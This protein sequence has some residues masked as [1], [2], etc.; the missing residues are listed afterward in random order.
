MIVKRHWLEELRKLDYAD[1]PKDMFRSVSRSRRVWMT[2]LVVAL[3]IKPMRLCGMISQK[4]EM[5]FFL[6][7]Q[8]QKREQQMIIHLQPK[9]SALLA[10]IK[11]RRMQFSVKNVEIN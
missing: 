11:T 1:H 5:S 2:V 3:L 8:Q 10:D 4:L 7:P 9:E 6:L